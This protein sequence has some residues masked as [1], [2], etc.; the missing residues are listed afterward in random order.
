MISKEVGCTLH[1]SRIDI[2]ANI[3]RVTSGGAK[4]NRIMYKCSLS[5]EQLNAYL[6]FLVSTGLLKSI[7]PRTGEKSGSNTY[8]ATE[9]GQAFIK[10]YQNLKALLIS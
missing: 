8:E 6:D 7:P 10:D 5:L 3:L 9:K 1:R 4:E 2:I